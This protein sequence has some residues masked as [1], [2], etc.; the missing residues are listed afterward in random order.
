[1]YCTYCNHPN[2]EGNKFCEACGKPLVTN[3]LPNPPIPP[4]LPPPDP[5]LEK[6]KRSLRRL[7][8]IGAVII[9]V[10][11]FFPW[12]LVSCNTEIGSNYQAGISVTGLQI[13]MGNLDDSS[14]SSGAPMMLILIVG[15]VGLIALSGRLFGTIM[16]ML[17]GILGIIMMAIFTLYV[18]YIN[19][20]AS[21]L[22]VSGYCDLFLGMKISLESGF[23]GTW[24]GLLWQTVTAF[25][26]LRIT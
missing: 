18:V 22:S 8:S 6:K 20:Y 3:A 13:A 12:L 7:P 9:L 15:L 1:M 19:S 17:S 10:S 16:S 23:W 26:T 4:P 5:G 2:K 24:F 25:K 21:S 11:F 14:D